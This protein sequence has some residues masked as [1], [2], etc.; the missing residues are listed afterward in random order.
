MKIEVRARRAFS[1]ACFLIVLL[2]LAACASSTRHSALFTPD[3][4]STTA[5]TSAATST[6][7]S[8]GSS[9]ASSS[10]AAQPSGRAAIHVIGDLQIDAS[11]TGATCAYFYPAMKEGVTYRVS[12]SDLHSSGG[13]GSW[14]LTLTDDTADTSRMAIN[15][16]TDHGAWTWA[17]KF[18]GAVV[19]DPQL[20]HAD[21]DVQ[22]VKVLGQQHARLTGHI[23]CP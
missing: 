10:A 2:F 8:T 20:H 23:D 12:S 9:V 7:A 6:A 19:A 22:L 13:A 14:A 17:A 1:L 18:G 15:F 5:V 4:S 11:G 21:F 16:N 3:P